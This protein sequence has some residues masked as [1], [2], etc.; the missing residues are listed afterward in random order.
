MRI[1]TQ[2]L[3]ALPKEIIDEFVKDMKNK[4]GK[5]KNVGST[6]SA[7]CRSSSGWQTESVKDYAIVKED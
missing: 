5:V 3:V 6:R 1:D 7:L 2:V 4:A